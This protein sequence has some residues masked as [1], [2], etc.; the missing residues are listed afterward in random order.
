M[1]R[2]EEQMQQI[3]STLKSW[4]AL[5]SAWSGLDLDI[6]RKGKSGSK[7]WSG[8][9]RVVDVNT[10]RSPNDKYHTFKVLCAQ[11]AFAVDVHRLSV[12]WDDERKAEYARHRAR[13][14]V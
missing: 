1:T 3:I 11:M 12:K 7:P 10:N 5:L 13:L 6:E 14:G 2:D 8:A 9:Y 4:A